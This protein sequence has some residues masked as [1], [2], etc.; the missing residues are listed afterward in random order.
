[1]FI[2]IEH[3]LQGALI[4]APDLQEPYS[5]LIA[6]EY[7][8]Y[9]SSL[10]RHELV[11]A[12]RIKRKINLYLEMVSLPER[13]KWLH[14]KEIDERSMLML[15]KRK[16]IFIGRK[17]L[18]ETGIASVQSFRLVSLIGT[19]GVGKTHL[20]L[21]IAKGWQQRHASEVIFCSAIEA[22]DE[23]G[24][25]SCIA[26]AASINLDGN[27]QKA[28][29]RGLD[30]RGQIV[31]VIDNVEQLTHCLSPLLRAMLAAA[32]QL[33]VM[34]TSRTRLGVDAEHILHVPTMSLLE[35]IL[36]FLARAQLQRPELSLSKRNRVVIGRIVERLD[37]LPL[38]IE[39]AIARTS[40]FSLDDIERH[41]STDFDLLQSPLRASNRIDLHGV[42]D[43]SWN[44]LKG[45]SR[46]VLA[47]CSV[48][49]GGFSMAA[50]EAI[51]DLSQWPDCPKVYDLIEAL[52]D[53]NLL[54]KE[55]QADGCYRYDMLASIQSYVRGRLAEKDNGTNALT[56][57]YHRHATY[58]ATLVNHMPKNRIA[59]E[60]DN[61]IQGV[62]AGAPESAVSCCQQAM[63]MLASLGPMSLG[64]DLC[65]QL[66]AREDISFE[67]KQPIVL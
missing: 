24:L 44:L 61:F 35:A 10:L 57:L 49:R 67:A 54:V 47:Q 15:R 25:L 65:A 31:L 32:P 14:R 8:N 48:F 36:L 1:M 6:I 11:V 28:L 34:I 66:L 16:G 26:D 52:V 40:I 51:V 17:D 5:R 9:V 58:F 7:E 2:E 50:A 64:V 13:R 23:N 45:W 39:L 46:S 38:A 60:I 37:R 42:F 21:E 30:A 4:Y 59:N 43:W 12:Q 3:A 63:L 20:S 27:P 55:R 41:L 62:H 33:K 22:N 19:A 18:V 29:F 53:D 56:D